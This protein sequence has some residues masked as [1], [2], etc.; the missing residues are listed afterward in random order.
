L[1]YLFA[2]YVLADLEEGT[3]QAVLT[4]WTPP[5]AGPF[6]YFPHRQLMPPGLRAFV[7][8]LKRTAPPS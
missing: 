3:L 1:A 5:F 2:E 6:L 4:D 7:D 8:F